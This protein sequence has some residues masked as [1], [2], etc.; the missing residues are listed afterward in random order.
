[1]LVLRFLRHLALVFG[2]FR[3]YVSEMFRGSASCGQEQRYDK[4]SQ[5]GIGAALADS[6]L[7]F[8]VPEDFVHFLCS[9]DFFEG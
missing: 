5:G 3:S 8:L 2:A 9:H 4:N 6:A 7:C 1:M